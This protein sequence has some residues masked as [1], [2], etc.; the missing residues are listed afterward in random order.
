VLFSM[1][2]PAFQQRAQAQQ[3]ALPILV[4]NTGALNARSGPGPEYTVITVVR[5]GTELPVLGTNASNTWYLVATAAGAAWVD[6]SFTLARGNFSFVP[7]IQPG[8]AI[9]IVPSGPSSVR[10]PSGTSTTVTQPSLQAPEVIV[11]TGRL[12]VRSGPGGQFTSIAV[13]SG[14]TSLAGLGVT[15]DGIW[16][17]VQGTFGRGWVAS[18][19][20]IVRGEFSNLAVI[21][22]AY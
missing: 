10:L 8:A 17:L 20:T 12:N 21:T 4:V 19:F 16:Y 3:V 1:A 11:N 2:F 5:G 13:V 18:E 15:T 6:V 22:D 14:G 9:S 7:T